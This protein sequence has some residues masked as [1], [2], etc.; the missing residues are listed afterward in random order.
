LRATV[1]DLARGGP[2]P[3]ARFIERTLAESAPYARDAGCDREL[4]GIRHILRDGNGADRQLSVYA[5]TGDTREVVRDIADVMR[6]GST[7]RPLRADR[8]RR[9]RAS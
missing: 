4:D 5:A 1:I 2:V 8:A 7:T 3:V 6:T 9:R